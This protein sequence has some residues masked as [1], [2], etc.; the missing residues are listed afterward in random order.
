MRTTFLTITLLLLATTLSAQ[1]DSKIEKQ[2]SKLFEK[3]KYEKCH[4]KARKLNGKYPKSNIPEYYIS[5]VAL[6]RY[7]TTSIDDKSHYRYLTQ[8]VN[9]SKGLPDDYSDW[10]NSIQDSIKGYIYYL[11]DCISKTRKFSIANKLYAKTYNDTLV[12][13]EVEELVERVPI[14]KFSQSTIDSLR[15]ELVKFAELQDGIRY[16]YAGEKPETGFDCSGFTMYVYSHIGVELPHNAQKQ[17]NLEG[18]N[19]SLDE[20]APGDLIFFGSQS[21]NSHYTVHAGIVHSIYE[22]DIE[23]IHCVSGGVSI[24][25]RN[26]SW[27]R[28]WKDKVLF[29]KTLPQLNTRR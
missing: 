19:K 9:Y 10:K 7:S 20:A 16:K 3:G 5:K 18:I 8:A 1:K 26:S 22:E 21:E 12:F 14:Y 25:G 28:Y 27:E 4:S 29:V 15:K 24:E 6:Y 23:V 11:H 17:S 13:S 2:L